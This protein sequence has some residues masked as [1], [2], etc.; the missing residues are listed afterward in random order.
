M[1]RFD[2]IP[3]MLY[4]DSSGQIYE[5]VIKSVEEELIV[6]ALERSFGNQVVAA[7]MLGLNRNTLHTKIKKLA[8]DVRRYKR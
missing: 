5:D 6:R 4:A 8:I 3:F 7:K 2:H 1:G